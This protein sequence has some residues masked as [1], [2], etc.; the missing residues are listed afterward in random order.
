MANEIEAL[1]AGLVIM[2]SVGVTIG[3]F[4]GGILLMILNG[5]LRK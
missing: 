4:S 5:Y 1:F 3:V 2:V